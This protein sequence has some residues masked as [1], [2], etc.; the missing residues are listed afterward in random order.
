MWTYRWSRLLKRQHRYCV[1]VI[2]IELTESVLLLAVQCNMRF[3]LL[4]NKGVCH[5]QKAF[6]W[7]ND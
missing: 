7:R 5:F 1:I 3:V 2:V 4:N 6:F